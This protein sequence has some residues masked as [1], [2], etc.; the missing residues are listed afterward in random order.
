M[1]T[2]EFRQFEFFRTFWHLENFN[3]KFPAL[4]WHSWSFNLKFPHFLPK[5]QKLRENSNFP[6]PEVSITIS[7]IFCAL[8]FQRL[9]VA[10]IPNFPGVTATKTTHYVAVDLTA[11]D[12]DFSHSF[13]WAT[14][15]LFYSL[16]FT[17]FQRLLGTLESRFNLQSP[18]CK[19]ACKWY[20]Q[21]R[22]AQETRLVLPMK[23]IAAHSGCC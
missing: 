23:R 1:L 13:S 11:V 12:R 22:T 10:W 21:K 5:C 9:T 6:N 15:P 14:T 8:K 4:F 2:T 19:G 17:F 16:L 20:P 18:H 7:Y 3:F